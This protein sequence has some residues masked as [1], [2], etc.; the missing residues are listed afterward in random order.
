MRWWWVVGKLE[1]E[2]TACLWKV[3][4]SDMGQAFLAPDVVTR[5]LAWS[6][7]ETLDGNSSVSH[8][9]RE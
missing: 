2:C 3:E 9:A 7:V 1:T 4:R 5:L 8:A 6:G